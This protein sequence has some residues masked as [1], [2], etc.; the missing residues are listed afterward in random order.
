MYKR[1]TKSSTNR[2]VS[3]VCAGI[4]EFYNLDPTIVRVAYAFLTIFSTVFPGVLLY[5]V[6]CI[7]VPKD[8][9][10]HIE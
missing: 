1:L 4:A 3:G 2:M 5:I 10:Y 7:I 9:T 8:D 6:L